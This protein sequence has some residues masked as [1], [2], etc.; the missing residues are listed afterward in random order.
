MCELE[1]FSPRNEHQPF[2]FYLTSVPFFCQ[3]F[4]RIFSPRKSLHFPLFFFVR[5]AV[6][7]ILATPVRA[8]PCLCAPF[9]P[10]ECFPVA[11]T[12]FE[13]NLYYLI[14]PLLASLRS[15]LRSS[16]VHETA[17][18]FPFFPSQV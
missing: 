12:V 9:L 13:D 5:E 2:L 1:K 3:Q 14:P 7:T 11:F 16:S 17:H 10:F 4:Y 18:L 6:E 15:I 8:N